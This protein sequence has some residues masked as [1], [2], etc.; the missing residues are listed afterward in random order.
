MLAP[1]TRNGS[2]MGLNNRNLLKRQ[3]TLLNLD[4]WGDVHVALSTDS[5]G[6]IRMPKN[7]ATFIAFRQIRPTAGYCSS[8]PGEQSFTIG[9]GSRNAKKPGQPCTKMASYPH[10]WTT[11]SWD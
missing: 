4:D 9:R 6:D 3:T 11:T 5:T 1:E 10:A 8:S 2:S 7:N